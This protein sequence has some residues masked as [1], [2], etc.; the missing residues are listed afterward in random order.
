MRIK[1]NFNV[2][3]NKIF[4]RIMLYLLSVASCDVILGCI[5]GLFLLNCFDA[6]KLLPYRLYRGNKYRH[7]P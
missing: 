1:V 6:M 7:F 5:S 4:Q 3:F 2:I